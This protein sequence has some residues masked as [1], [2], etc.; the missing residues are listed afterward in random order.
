MDGRTTSHDLARSRGDGIAKRMDISSEFVESADCGWEG[1]LG[2]GR[3]DPLAKAIQ[4]M[5]E[6]LLDRHEPQ[7]LRVQVRRQVSAAGESDPHLAVQRRGGGGLDEGK[8][9]VSYG[10][11]AWGHT[12]LEHVERAG[13]DEVSSGH[14]G[15]HSTVPWGRLACYLER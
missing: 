14:Q 9:L 12:L 3:R 1:V 5:E 6:V 15:G 8:E 13:D 11:W 10:H 7:L 2:G 4:P